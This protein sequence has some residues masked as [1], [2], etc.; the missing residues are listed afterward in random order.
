MLPTEE[1]AISLA[2]QYA[3]QFR[4]DTALLTFNKFDTGYADNNLH[5]EL[6]SIEQTNDTIVWGTVVISI[7]EN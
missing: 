7:G 4:I 2:F 5:V 3:E 1:A 6:V